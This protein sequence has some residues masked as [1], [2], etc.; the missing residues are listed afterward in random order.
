M[1]SQAWPQDVFKGWL[2]P[3]VAGMLTFPGGCGPRQIEMPPVPP[4]VEASPP[5]PTMRFETSMNLAEAAIRYRNGS[6]S[7]RNAILESLGVEW[8]SLISI[9]TGLSTS[10]FPVAVAL[11]ERRF[12]GGEPPNAATGAGSV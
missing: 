6:E 5:L 1:V 8:A 10:A 3:L 12:R 4:V 2:L 9:S 7:Q 11:W